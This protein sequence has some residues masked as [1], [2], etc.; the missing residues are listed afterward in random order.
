M[1]INDKTKLR[2]LGVRQKFWWKN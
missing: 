2:I 1:D